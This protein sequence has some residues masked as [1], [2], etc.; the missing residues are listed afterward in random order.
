MNIHKKQKKVQISKIF[1]CVMLLTMLAGKAYSI[2]NIEPKDITSHIETEY[3]LDHSVPSN[4]I[5]VSTNE[6]IVT[7]TG[8]VNNLLAKERAQK[9]AEATVG[10]RAI[11]NRINVNPIIDLDDSTV[12]N[13]VENALLNDPATD[14]YE[15]LVD[16][17][18]G[19][20]KL[21]GTVDSWQEK[22]LC[23][24]VAKGVKGV[25]SIN[26]EIDVNYKTN[27]PDYEIKQEVIE[28]LANDVRVDDALINVDVENEKV[29]LSG[30]VGSLQEKNQAIV[31][32]WVG[33][34]NN[35]VS[36][37]LDIKWWARD[38]MRRKKLYKSLSDSEVEEA[39]ED[40]FV[41]DPRVLS[42]DVD[43]DVNYGTV[44]LSGIVDNLE[45]KNSAKET[46]SN[47]LGVNRVINNI[48]VRPATILS[49]NKLVS[50]VGNAMYNDP[51]IER[52]DINISAHG[53]TVYLSG[54]VNTS[55]EK[56]RAKQ[57]T[58]GVQGAL[59][60]VNNIDYD[61]DWTW[62]PDWEIRQA[63]KDE[64]FWSPFVDRDDIE[65]EVD[66]GVVTL[67]GKVDT[68][69]ERQSATE[70]AYE[71]G[72]KDVVNDLTV[73]YSY[74]GPIYNGPYSYYNYF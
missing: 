8:S 74:Y 51:Y 58:E 31:D 41:Y 66:D 49:D 45:A 20:V 30:T 24:I 72:A 16:V 19:N 3:W 54:K 36:K 64:L 27:R 37:D 48:K 62:K 42:F 59:Y 55:W 67:N 29:K 70:N 21:S 13:K 25:T 17:K 26:N 5:N 28:R 14:L 52:F 32:S 61:Y 4:G 47:T 50:R 34:V 43:V 46:A 35:V 18:K 23:E 44:T 22:N 33:G 71:A 40:A 39:V 69:S 68:F 53:G 15:I 12:E 65:I 38:E 57:I 56:A 73:A 10:V 1:V 2:P 9:I 7:L 6:G 11:I 60:V 63:V